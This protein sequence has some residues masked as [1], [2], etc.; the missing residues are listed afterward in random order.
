MKWI[1]PGATALAVAAAAALTSTV[2]PAAPMPEAAPEPIP[3]YLTAVCPAFE[4]ATASVRVAVTSQAG[5]VTTASLAEPPPAGYAVP[6]AAGPRDASTSIAEM[7]R[8][9]A[10][11]A[12]AGVGA[13]RSLL[14]R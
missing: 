1:I 8:S 5:T 9:A 4:S 13:L 11:L 12:D 6:D 2:W 7:V 14:G 10:Q 3:V